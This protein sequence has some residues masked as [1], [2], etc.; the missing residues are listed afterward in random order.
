LHF[1]SCRHV[2]CFPEG[3]KQLSSLK[4]LHL[5]L[6][7]NISALPEW[8]SD[9]SSLEKLVITECRS[10]KSLPLCIQQLTNLQ[11]LHISDNEELHQWCESEENKAKLAH[12]KFKVSPPPNCFYIQI[13]IK[14][15][16]YKRLIINFLCGPQVNY[17]HLLLLDVQGSLF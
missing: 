15:S 1:S 4:S 2:M 13:K 3:V 8:L 10:I 11:N 5:Y 12:I 16:L 6:C 14:F 17:L 7:D 9:I